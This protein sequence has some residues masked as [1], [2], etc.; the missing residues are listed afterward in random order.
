MKLVAFV[1]GRPH[2]Q[3]RTTQ[4][5]KFLFGSSVEHWM[6]VDADNAEKAALGLYNKKGKPYRPTR[7]AYRLQRMLKINEY[8]SRVQSTVMQYC[9]GRKIPTQFLFMFYLF[10][11]PKSWSKK[12]AAGVEWQFHVFKPD[13]KNILTGVEDSLYEQDSYCNAVAHYKIYVP[14]TYK[15]GLLILE[16][17]EIHRYVMEMAFDLFKELKEAKV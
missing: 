16:N 14:K 5:V 3:P 6:K 15:Q 10:H 17:E 8:R 4:K 13:Y 7:Y 9:N 12:K 11:T 2:P 1:E